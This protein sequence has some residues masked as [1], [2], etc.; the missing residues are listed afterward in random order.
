MPIPLFSDTPVNNNT[1]YSYDAFDDPPESLH[2]SVFA[3]S[4]VNQ[5][6]RAPL[7]MRDTMELL[8]TPTFYKSLLTVMTTKW[9]LFTFFAL[10]PSFLMQEVNS[11]NLTQMC[12]LMGIMSLTTLLFAG[13]AYWIN[14]EKRWRA[15]MVWFLSWFGALGYFSKCLLQCVCD[16]G[17]K[18]GNSDFRL[19]HRRVDTIR[20]CNDCVEYCGLATCR[21]PPP[22]FNYQRGTYQRVQSN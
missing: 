9:S 7:V 22:R 21:R 2:S 16:R 12:T 19:L 17:T 13:A 4:N 8:R 6:A 15:K 14:V 18:P 10:F 3:P 20:R 5:T 11:V 1:S